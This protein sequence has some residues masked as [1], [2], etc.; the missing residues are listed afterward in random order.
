MEQIICRI[1]KKEKMKK[2]HYERKRKTVD[3]TNVHTSCLN[4]NFFFFFFSAGSGRYLKDSFDSIPRCDLSNGV[5]LCGTPLP[6][7]NE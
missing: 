5:V 7:G 6:K 3:R 2:I 1:K 4:L